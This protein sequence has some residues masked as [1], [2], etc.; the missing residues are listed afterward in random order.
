MVQ[1]VKRRIY[2]RAISARYH[3]GV[4][5]AAISDRNRVPDALSLRDAPR[6]LASA[7]VGSGMSFFELDCFRP[8]LGF[9]TPV[10]D[11]A[12]VIALQLK[13]CPNFDLYSDGR[14]IRPRQFDAGAVAIFD[15][16]STLATDIRD[17][18]HAIDLYLPITAL[19]AMS[20]DLGRARI[21][22]LR[23]TPGTAVEDPTTRNLLM[24][25]RPG[26]AAPPEH[27]SA[28]F[29]DHVA[30]A[31]ATHLAHRYGGMNV[32]A[33]RTRGGLAPVQARRAQ[34]LLSANLSG[35]ILLADLA[36]AC[37]LSVRQFTRA[38]RQSTG[39]APH[40]WLVQRRLEKA[41]SLLEDTKLS[42]ADVASDCGFADQSHFTRV[43]MNAVGAT[44]GEWRRMLRR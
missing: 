5:F 43:F 23:H 24:S 2:A 18:F 14:L 10:R 35:R 27:T 8:N 22:E 30:L 11:D 41:K 20:D 42:L 15:L 26:L 16:R 40:Q 7:A 19:N 9:T 4:A 39:L 37:D 21:D 33:L 36:K 34:E 17:P 29:V 25:M 1:C 28:L 3:T 38:F 32:P 13:T 6:L 31:I 44:P 12:F